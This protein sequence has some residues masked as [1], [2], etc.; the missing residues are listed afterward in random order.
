MPIFFGEDK[1]RIVVTPTDSQLANMIEAGI[2][3]YL[4]ENIGNT[5]RLQIADTFWN[6]RKL[7]KL[8]IKFRK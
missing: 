3:D 5:T 4:I 2:E 7:K 8:K 6:R 1:K